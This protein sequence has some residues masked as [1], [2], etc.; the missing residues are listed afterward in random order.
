MHVRPDHAW[1]RLAR[2][3]HGARHRLFSV[4]DPEADA[5][6]DFVRHLDPDS[7]IVARNARIEPSVAADPPGTRYQ[8]ER[9]GYFTSDAADSKPGALVFNRTVTLRDTWAKI[10]GRETQSSGRPDRRRAHASHTAPEAKPPREPAA[11]AVGAD[12]VSRDAAAARLLEDAVAAGADRRTA[13]NWINNDVARELAGRPASLLTFGGVQLAA[14]LQL[15]D[16]NAISASSA[17]DV[18]T[19]MVAQGG[20]ASAIVERRGLTQIRDVDAIARIVDAVIGANAARVE[21]YRRGRTGLL[22]F[23]VGQ[24]MKETSG[25]AEPAV[26]QSL[27]RSRLEPGS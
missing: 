21:E 4:A 24:V 14:L 12:L 17:R 22:G 11:P 25:R 6:G 13:L 23:F 5:D 2:R 18:L 9:L 1:W 20:D 27:V 7:L 16:R 10:A 19:E 26:V 15:L 3:P 8:F